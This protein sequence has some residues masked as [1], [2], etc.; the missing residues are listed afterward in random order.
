[1]HVTILNVLSAIFVS[2]QYTAVSSTVAGYFLYL[3]EGAMDA[4]YTLLVI[5]I[6]FIMLKQYTII[7]YTKND[8]FYAY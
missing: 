5:Y 7:K 4:T 1:M 8:I 3:G 2:S 6:N